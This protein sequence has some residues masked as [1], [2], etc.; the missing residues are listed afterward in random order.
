MLWSLQNRQL[1]RNLYRK[2]FFGPNDVL[3]MSAKKIEMAITDEKS[4]R[5]SF[6]SGSIF[7]RAVCYSYR[8]WLEFNFMTAILHGGGGVGG[9]KEGGKN[10]SWLFRVRV[11]GWRL[12]VIHERDWTF[13]K[14]LYKEASHF[15][16]K[17]GIK[18]DMVSSWFP[19][20][21]IPTFKTCHNDLLFTWLLNWYV[22]YDIA[23]CSN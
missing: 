5:H 18:K 20:D 3:P 21:I 16:I 15:M 13:L 23:V 12:T 4:F 9:W 8:K 10:R 17:L 2:I 19:C 6:F 22:Q 11:R 14:S 1:Y 7:I